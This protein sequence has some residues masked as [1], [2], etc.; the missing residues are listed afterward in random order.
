[1]LSA[2]TLRSDGGLV[3]DVE[4]DAD[5]DGEGAVKPHSPTRRSHI[6]HCTISV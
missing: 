1:M 6:R 2:D 4:A 5:G 3:A